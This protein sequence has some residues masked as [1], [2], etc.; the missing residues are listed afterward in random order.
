MCRAAGA[1]GREPEPAWDDDGA[2]ALLLGADACGAYTALCARLSR[3]LH[4]E[5]A[6]AAAAPAAPRALHLRHRYA[7]RAAL[8]V[9]LVA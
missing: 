9:T 8:Q 6:A 4:G 7:L 2:A 3:G 1:A 5:R